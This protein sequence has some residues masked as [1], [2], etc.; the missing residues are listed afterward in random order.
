MTWRHRLEAA[1][2]IHNVLSLA[3]PTAVGKSELAVILA[4]RLDGE[5][6]SVDSMQVYRGMDLGTAKPTAEQRRRVPHHLLDVVDVASS[7][8]AAQFVRVAT[9]AMEDIKSRGHLPILCGGTGFYFKALFSGL[10]AAP[11]ANPR[12]RAELEKSPMP[13][14]LEELAAK[15]PRL[16]QTID[17]QNSR[18]I[19]RA[20]EVLRQTGKPFSEQRA[21]WDEQQDRNASPILCLNRA[22]AELRARIDHRVDEM[23]RLGLLKETEDL[24]KQGLAQ[25]STAMQALGYRQV[26]EHLRGERPLSETIELVKIR[27]RQYAKRQLTWFRKQPGVDWL[28]LGPADSVNDIAERVLAA[29]GHE[30]R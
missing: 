14:L 13:A 22:P 3:G 23:F 8:D 26:V 12:L 1:Q 15:D 6:V 9:K 2:K 5:I 11:P 7:F 24:L 19:I 16:Y 21:A 17:R 25:N 27:T 20:V 18:R 10:G 28:D 29:F 4:E 30:L